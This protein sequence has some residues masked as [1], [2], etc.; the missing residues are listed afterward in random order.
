M[1][2]T[3]EAKIR[4]KFPFMSHACILRTFGNG[5]GSL[6]Q[7]EDQAVRMSVNRS[8]DIRPT[9]DEEAL[10]KTEKDYLTFLVGQRPQWCGVKSITLKLGH[11]CRFTPDFWM[12]DETGLRAIDTK[13]SWKGGQ[14]HVEDDAM[15][16]LK[17]A[18]RLFPFIH[19]V[20]AWKV[21]EVWQHKTIKP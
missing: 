1:S 8:L 2:P 20:I 5:N 16:K 15:V 18:A 11:D 7:A 21:G 17:V 14:P 6:G 4:A 12:L 3:D 13:A 19:F 10:N 9:T